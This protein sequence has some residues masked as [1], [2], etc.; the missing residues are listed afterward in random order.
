MASRKAGAP[1]RRIGRVSFYEH[2]GGYWLYHTAAGLALRG[3]R[4]EAREL[5]ER[6]LALRSDVGLLSEEYDP[7]AR[8]RVGTFPQAFT[9]VGLVNTARNR[10]RDGGPAEERRR[11]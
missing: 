2:H 3:R 6:L 10:T 7:V 9:H 4:A 1:R 11:A 5:F 8:R